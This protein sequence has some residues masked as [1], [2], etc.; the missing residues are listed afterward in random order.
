MTIW[1]PPTW[2]WAMDFVPVIF[3]PFYNIFLSKLRK[4]LFIFPF[5]L[6]NLVRNYQLILINDH[7]P[8]AWDHLTFGSAP[9]GFRTRDLW[10]SHYPG[11]VV[12]IPGGKFIIAATEL[13]KVILLVW[14]Y[15]MSFKIHNACLGVGWMD[16]WVDG[17]VDGLVD[18]WV[19]RW[20]GGWMDG[21]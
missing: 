13:W 10:T 20:V 4:Y 14:E 12:F 19:D 17:W 9:N 6:S 18:G 7:Q 15:I 2:R 16:G 11:Q 21:W 3:Y 5:K 8:N 1:P